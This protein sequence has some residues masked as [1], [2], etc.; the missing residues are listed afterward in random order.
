RR[1]SNDSAP[2]YED[3]EPQI[4]H[5]AE[6]P[7]NPRR[8]RRSSTDSLHVVRRPLP[9]D[10]NETMTAGDFRREPIS[11]TP[12][13]FDLQI[14][15][16]IIPHRRP[17][18]D[19]H[20]NGYYQSR[21]ERPPYQPSYQL[22]GGDAINHQPPASSPYKAEAN[23]DRARPRLAS[24]DSQASAASHL[25]FDEAADIV[26]RA[27]GKP[28]A[29][30]EFGGVPLLHIQEGTV[31]AKLMFIYAKAC[32]AREQDITT[33]GNHDQPLKSDGDG[34]N[35]GG[36]IKSD[37]EMEIPRTPGNP[38]G[39][40]THAEYLSYTI[41]QDD[42]LTSSAPHGRRDA[43]ASTPMPSMSSPQT[44]APPSPGPLV[45]EPEPSS[46]IVSEDGSV[47]PPP[48]AP[49]SPVPPTEAFI[50]L[51]DFVVSGDGSLT[52]R[53][54][55]SS[56]N[57]TV[58]PDPSAD[59]DKLPEPHPTTADNS[60]T[61]HDSAAEEP[62]PLEPEVAHPAD[63]EPTEQSEPLADDDAVSIGSS[64]ERE[65]AASV[66]SLD[67]LL[68]LPVKNHNHDDEEHEEFVDDEE[69]EEPTG[70]EETKQKEQEAV[71]TAPLD[72]PL[73]Q[74]QE[75]EA[76]E[77]EE[78][79][80]AEKE[81]EQ[82]EDGALTNPLVDELFRNVPDVREVVKDKPALVVLVKKSMIDEIQEILQS[83]QMELQFERHSTMGVGS[84]PSPP[85]HSR[86]STLNTEGK[87]CFR[88]DAVGELAELTL[89]GG[90][91][92]LYCQECWELFFFSEDRQS[93]VAAGKE[94][95]PSEAS[96]LTADEDALDEA[97]KYS[98]HDSSVTRED[99]IHPWRYLQGSDSMSSIRDS[100]TSN[101]S[102]ITDRTDERGFT[103]EFSPLAPF[104]TLLYSLPLA[105]EPV[106][107]KWA[108]DIFPAVKTKLRLG[109]RRS[110]LN[111]DEL[112]D[113][114]SSGSSSGD[115]EA[116]WSSEE[117]SLD[118]YWTDGGSSCT[119][120]GDRWYWRPASPR[121]SGMRG[122][123]EEDE[124]VEVGPAVPRLTMYAMPS[125][126]MGASKL[127]DAWIERYGST[128]SD[129]AYVATRLQPSDDLDDVHQQ[130]DP[131]V[132]GLGG[133]YIPVL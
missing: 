108:D 83:L 78:A 69:H 16:R 32:V 91:R 93:P 34:N 97:L 86:L 109:I 96:R 113:S 4:R 115:E 132:S 6:R 25:S 90:R 106:G 3:R 45:P 104:R 10:D 71:V 49:T 65:L 23:D 75:E 55:T 105:V 102:S 79:E 2:Y 43:P 52:E 107:P 63:E 100:A 74:V 18:T 131:Q 70:A 54:T 15:A 72:M 7:T 28:A 13:P 77:T 84:M 56:L 126:D 120:E 112:T 1:Y 53:R 26:A 41:L 31:Q 29:D 38:L 121:E 61:S 128:K 129:V 103:R 19:H 36:P 12:P 33:D 42:A 114:C 101:N 110:L 20:H 85:R 67:D 5:M 48:A 130:H 58:T 73:P 57:S 8:G 133:F 116:E 44:K 123:Y 24:R 22:L 59:G 21:P 11:E 124:A 80:E 92:E 89:A 46:S 81:E 60:E 125:M 39:R 37:G 127:V 94:L 40:K 82:P 76:E 35:N 99:M 117:G 119:F 47:P 122:Q 27:A 30:C 62:A 50:S 98:F 17:P 66:A 87:H 118:G 9:Y 111:D 64:N 51:K 68:D 14:D 95:A 88:C